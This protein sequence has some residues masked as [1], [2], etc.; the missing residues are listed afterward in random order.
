MRRAYREAAAIRARYGAPS[1]ITDPAAAYTPAIYDQ[2]ALV[3]EALRREVGDR[4]FLAIERALLRRFADRPLTT[5]GFVRTAS[6]VA[7]RDL[8]PFLEAWLRASEVP[9]MPGRPRWRTAA[10]ASPPPAPS[11]DASALPVG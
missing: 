7:G 3:L 2:G 10:P 4:T 11:P 9:P 6:R 5:D 8:G 1:A